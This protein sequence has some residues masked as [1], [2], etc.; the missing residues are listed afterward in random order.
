MGTKVVF[1]YKLL[2][3][4]CHCAM[5]KHYVRRGSYVRRRVN[6]DGGRVLLGHLVGPEEGSLDM[7]AG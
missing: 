1:G 6:M 4:L 7:E 3:F 5:H 2:R